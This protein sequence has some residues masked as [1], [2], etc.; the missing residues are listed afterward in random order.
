MFSLLLFYTCFGFGEKFPTL[1]A[2]T[3]NSKNF[4]PHTRAPDS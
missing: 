3:S 2:T 1:P 4:L